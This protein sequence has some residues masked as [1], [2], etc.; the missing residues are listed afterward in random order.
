MSIPDNTNN[1]LFSSLKKQLLQNWL[2]TV[3]KNGSSDG[4]WNI[5]WFSSNHYW[6]WL[7]WLETLPILA[8]VFRS[9]SHG[10]HN[11]CAYQNQSQ[12]FLGPKNIKILRWLWKFAY[13]SSTF[14]KSLKVVFRV[15]PLLCN[16]QVFLM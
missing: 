1:D 13:I 8:F 5:Q 16:W 15:L 10:F 7:R 3:M 11:H 2:L 4:W 14:F 6:D 9:V 12:D